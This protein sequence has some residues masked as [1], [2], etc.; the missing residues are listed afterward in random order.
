MSFSTNGIAQDQ[1]AALLFIL[2]EVRVHG[3]RLGLR[4]LFA[5]RG[6]L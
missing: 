2:P 4:G 1:P 3:K 5:L 6:R